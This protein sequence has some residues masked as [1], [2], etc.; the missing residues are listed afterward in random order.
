MLERKRDGNFAKD[1]EIHG[2]SNNSTAQQQKKTLGHDADV[3][4]FE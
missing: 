2:E 4:G 3:A 1:R